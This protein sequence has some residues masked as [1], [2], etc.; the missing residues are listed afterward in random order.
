[1]RKKKVRNCLAPRHSESVYGIGADPNLTED[2]RETVLK[3]AA[4]ALV[5]RED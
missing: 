2:E 1:M 3:L 5:R 4:K